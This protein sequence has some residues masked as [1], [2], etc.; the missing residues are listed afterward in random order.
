MSKKEWPKCEIDE[1]GN[2]F[3][4][5]EAGEWHREDGPA[6]EWVDGAKTW[7]RNGKCHRED[8]PAVEGI[9]G[10]KE[11]YINGLLHRKDGPAIE[12]ANGTKEWFENGMWFKIEKKRKS[13]LSRILSIILE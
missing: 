12:W 3:W 10:H 6:I 5:N 8:G 9:S 2:K 4:R 7:C 11:W 1:D 13:K